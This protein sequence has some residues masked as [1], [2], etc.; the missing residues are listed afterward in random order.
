[1]GSYRDTLSKMNRDELDTELA[2]LQR[3]QWENPKYSYEV[4]A[5]IHTLLSL[6]Q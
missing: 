6:M 5:K 1:M 3:I 4:K 2:C